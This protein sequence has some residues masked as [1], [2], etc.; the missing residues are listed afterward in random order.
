[1]LARVATFDPLPEGVNP[2]AV[3]LLRKT[4]R[5][6]PGFVAGYHLGAPGRRSLSITIFED[7]EAGRAAGA[8]LAGRPADQ[9][10]GI[11][12]DHVEFFEVEPF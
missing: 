1:M 3:Q 8:A 4:I 12:P 7:A 11:E 10:V 2:E 5:D 6:T 9:R